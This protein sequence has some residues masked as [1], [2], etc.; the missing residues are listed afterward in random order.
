MHQSLHSQNF[1][2]SVLLIKW[3]IPSDSISFFFFF[4]NVILNV[5][6][7]LEGC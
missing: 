7:M 1:F 4:F 3:Y 5:Q 6:Q 2:N